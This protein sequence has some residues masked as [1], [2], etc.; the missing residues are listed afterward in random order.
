V[1]ALGAALVMPTSL[2]LLLAAFPADQRTRAVGTWASI[3]AVAA[4]L[5][6]PLGGVLV[7]LSW[8]WVFLVNV[9]VG[10]VALV[11]GARVL[12]EPDTARTGMPDLLA[13]LGLVVGVGAL[14][15]A[16]VRVADDGATSP[17]VS[18]GAVVAVLALAWTVRRSGHHPVPALDLE[19]LRT[20]RIALAGL[21]MLAFTTGFAAMLV[22]NVLYLTGTWGWS[23]PRAGLA[24][25]AGP[26]VVVVIA[27]L[28]GRLSARWGLGTVAA[29]GGV[30][31]ALAGLWWT[32]A[33]GVT[34]DYVVACSRANCSPGSASG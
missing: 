14:A 18:A 1:Q 3:G 8:H 2:S 20:P 5:G 11:A 30:S 22:V 32:V 23:A 4:A 16:I 9:P 27:R 28:A 21:A 34:P 33:L 13:A 29:L 15:F 25:A 31:F 12:R 7:E 10:L 26:L 19:V 24:L 6:P 17:T